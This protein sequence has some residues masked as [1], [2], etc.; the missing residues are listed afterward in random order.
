MIAMKSDTLNLPEDRNR[1]QHIQQWDS[2][3]VEEY[4]NFLKAEVCR[5]MALPRW[6]M[7]SETAATIH[8]RKMVQATEI[9]RREI[10][11]L[12]NLHARPLIIFH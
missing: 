3:Y 8:Y 7:T 2:P 1:I 12:T 11:R 4:V 5:A 10:V 6:A 9:M